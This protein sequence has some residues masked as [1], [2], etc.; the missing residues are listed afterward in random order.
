MSREVKRRADVIGIFLIDEA[1][2]RLVGALMLETTMNG[3]SPDYK[4]RLKPS[5]A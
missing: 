1:I 5:L 2:I 4:C 3:S